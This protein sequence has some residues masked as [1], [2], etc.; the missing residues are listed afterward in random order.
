MGV[1]MPGYIMAVERGRRFNSC[2]F[3]RYG[4]RCRLFLRCVPEPI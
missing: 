1:E 2:F 4:V 3:I